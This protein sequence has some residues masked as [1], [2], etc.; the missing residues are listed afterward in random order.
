MSEFTIEEIRRRKL[1]RIETLINHRTE[2]GNFE[3]EES[4]LMAWL[5]AEMLLLE[6]KLQT[7]QAQIKSLTETL[8]KHEEDGDDL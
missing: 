8:F 7:A 3:D 2:Y 1:A 6:S 4:A 5:V